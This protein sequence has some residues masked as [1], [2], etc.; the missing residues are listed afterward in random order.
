MPEPPTPAPVDTPAPTT[1]APVLDQT[2]ERVHAKLNADSAADLQA[3]IEAVRASMAMEAGCSP[4]EITGLEIFPAEDPEAGLRFSLTID[5]DLDDPSALESLKTEL[6]SELA[7]ELTEPPSN[8]EITSLR[9]GSTIAG[10]FV[11]GKDRARA[12]AWSNRLRSGRLSKR[13]GKYTVKAVAVSPHVPATPDATGWFTV[14]AMLP[15]YAAGILQTKYDNGSVQSFAGFPTVVVPV[16]LGRILVTTYVTLAGSV[17]D[18]DVERMRASIAATAALSPEAASLVK[19]DVTVV[20][21]AVG[22][23]VLLKVTLPSFGASGLTSAWT[24]GKLNSLDSRA[25]TSLTGSPPTAAPTLSL[26]ASC[27]SLGTCP[28]PDGCSGHG[29]CDGKTGVCS[30]TTG[31]AGKYTG[32]ADN[33]AEWVLLAWVVG[34]TSEFSTEPAFVPDGIGLTKCAQGRET[35]CLATSANSS[36]ALVTVRTKVAPNSEVS[37]SVKC[38]PAAACGTKDG[39]GKV[40]LGPAKRVA[41][42]TV[43]GVVDYEDDGTE[44]IFVSIGPCNSTDGRFAINFASTSSSWG[45]FKDKA[46]H[47]SNL[48]S[49]IPLHLLPPAL[50]RSFCFR[51]VCSLERGLC[52]SASD[53]VEVRWRWKAGRRFGG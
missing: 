21:E 30:C 24:A 22:N 47:D 16:P 11:R 20:A 10:V 35:E 42:T 25:V 5:A 7:L 18:L 19:D 3:G 4:S 6:V 48:S 53:F 27:Q 44:K 43:Y 1:A 41:T 51:V 45:G 37:C 50:V 26:P 33:C 46:S 34:N 13:I 40:V 39:E 52:V 28:C 2:P 12:A 49:A 14:S 23:S 9:A 31:W 17:T 32:N 36:R 8:I 15:A 29:S 38:S